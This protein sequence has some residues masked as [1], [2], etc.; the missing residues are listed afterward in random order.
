MRR[1]AALLTLT[2]LGPS[3]LGCEGIRNEANADLPVW[4]NRAGWVMQLE[5]K[6]DLAAP[7]R[8]TGEPYERGEPEIDARGRRVFVGSSDGA[9]YALSAPEGDPLWRFQTLSFVQSS[10]YYDRKENVLYFGSHDGAFYK[11]DADSGRL[12]WRLSTR[13]EVARRPIL[14]AGLV[15]LANANDTIIAADAAT[16]QIRWSHHRTPA[17]GMEIAGYSGTLLFNGLV[18]MG[19]SDG[20]VSAFDAISGEERWQ[21]VDLAAEA[22]EATGEVPKYL[23]VDTTPELVATKDGWAVVV[24]SYVGG[25]YALEPRVG[26]ILWTNSNIRGVSDVGYYEEPAHVVEG[27]ERPQRRMLLV[28]TGSSGLWALDPVDG[29]VIWHRDLPAG[30]VS[31]P[32]AISGAILINASQQGTYLLS[33]V[34]G[35]LI[36]G[37]H[38]DDGASGTPAALGQH[39]FVMTNGGSLLALRLNVP[40]A[41]IE[42]PPSEHRALEGF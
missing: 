41:H 19:F 27:I 2:L 24:G 35:S 33:P 40:S 17:M 32:V 13:A 12:I 18:Y 37:I 14:S 22:E 7:S 4:K 6:R 5:Y 10:P 34:D 1:L 15:Y 25:V 9:L 3:S 29:S 21:P 23:D 38:L 30:G 31:R 26:T 20:T 8:K 36:D 28:S 16:G 11:V 42:T 39:A